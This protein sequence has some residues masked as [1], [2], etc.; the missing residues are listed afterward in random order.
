MPTNKAPLKKEVERQ[1][2]EVNEALDNS[3]VWT[4]TELS[5]LKQ[6]KENLLKIMDICVS[7]NRW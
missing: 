2:R 1:L 5:L 3:S 6:Q 4:N 7:R